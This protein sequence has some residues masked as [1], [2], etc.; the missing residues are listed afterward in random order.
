[1]A[2]S[3]ALL[4]SGLHNSVAEG[5]YKEIQS[6]CTSYYYFL[7]KTLEWEDEGNPPTPVDS[8]KYS[9]D[10]RNEIITLKQ[11]KSTDVAFVIP[12]V[13]WQSNVVYDQFDDRYSD[14]VIGLDII[15]GG[16]GY[17]D[18]PTITISGG[19][20]TGA[21]AVATI[22]EGAVVSITLTHAGRG[23]T[24]TPTVTITG[25]GGEGCQAEAVLARGASG[26][27]RIEDANMFVLTD[28]Y[29]VYKC[30]DNN[31]NAESTYKPIGTVVDPVIMPDGYM[32]KYLY[33]IPIAL[34]N[35]FLT[36]S[37]MPVI[38]SLKQQFYSNGEILAMTVDNEGKDYTFMNI[39][40]TGDGYL[41]ADPL[42]LSSITISDGG[43]NY[44][45]APTVTFSAPFTDA[46]IW[47]D[48]NVVLL[49]QRIQYGVHQYE[50]VKSGALASPAPTHRRGI[51]DNGSAALKYIG[52]QVTGT[53]TINGSNEVSGVVLDGMIYD[54]E[55]TDGGTGYTSAPSVNIS[56]GGGSGQVLSATMSGTSVAYVT[57]I[58][59]GQGFTSTPTVT[60]GD[61]WQ[62]STAYSTGDQIYYA[63]RL[64]TVTVGG[65]SGTTAPTHNSSTAS[66]GTTTLEYV[67]EPATGDVVLKYGSG[68][69]SLPSIAFQPVSG[70][71]NA[72]AYMSGAKSEAQ[73]YPV[74]DTGRID[75]IIVKDGGV[76]YTY[77][78]IT[79][80]GDGTDAQITP[81]LSPGSVDTLQA[82]TE[83][84]TTA[85]QI[86]SCIVISGGYGY[87]A[88][89]TVT[90][91]GDGTGAEA[92]AIVEDGRVKKIEM[93]NYGSGYR[94]AN[95]TISTAGAGLGYAATARAV[96]TPYGGHG[97]DPINGTYAST[98]MFYTNISKDKN[99]GFDVNND[100][101]QLG[102]LKHPR[103]YTHSS[104]DYAS[105]KE[106]LGSACYVFT[107]NINTSIFT[108]DLDLYL[109]GTDGEHFRIVSTTTTG[110]L[111]QSLDNAEAEIG[112]VLTD[113]DG[114]QFTISGVVEPTVDKYSGDLLFIDNK[115]A[116]TPTEDQTVTLRTVLKF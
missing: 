72:E 33:T 82:N 56:G 11:V 108:P 18:P 24:S 58:D 79:I 104:N 38:N 35:K 86:M 16:F 8:F 20:G 12:R 84:L 31:Q 102:I 22:V 7:G 103:K 40:V 3:S 47:G 85:G 63:N 4:K 55:M 66:N 27:Q 39:T 92:I 105:F 32:W 101:R 49:G 96:M 65:T 48:G 68:Y 61:Q 13:N 29:H 69:S 5:L 98:L 64:Y 94:W 25:G 46:A 107:G 52:T 59:S 28:E 75:S 100:F 10:T 50:V 97:K 17:A 113:A 115:Q 6:N 42:L 90:I 36:E 54:I 80:T 87:G 2:T 60:F 41:E 26:T 19:G 106:T 114:N 67:G 37:Y 70:G 93:T 57:V 21:T 74:L 111:C 62:A 83:L 77:A 53:A 1:M 88:A 81:D 15:S 51:V 73:I 30:L 34:R 44:A 9:L 91:E 116:F 45:V 109:N 71:T 23:Y 14:E 112:D 76:G 43:E 95:V 110:V 99:Q 78:N 89:P